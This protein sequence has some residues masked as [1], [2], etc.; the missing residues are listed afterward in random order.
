MQNHEKFRTS[1]LGEEAHARIVCDLVAALRTC[2]TL[3]TLRCAVIDAIEQDAP[4]TLPDS[5]P[6]TDRES[7]L[8][9]EY[10]VDAW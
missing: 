1:D 3:T 8:G 4:D 7:P 9:R 6:A 5:A 2:D 10:G